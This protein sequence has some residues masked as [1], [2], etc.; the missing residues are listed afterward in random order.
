MDNILSLPPEIFRLQVVDVFYAL[1][2]AT[3]GGL[4]SWL[5]THKYD[6]ANRREREESDRRMKL[7]LYRSVMAQNLGKQTYGWTY[8]FHRNPSGL[9]LVLVNSTGE[10]V[11]GL[12][13]APASYDWMWNK[14]RPSDGSRP[15]EPRL[16]SASDWS[17]KV[18]ILEPDNWN[19]PTQEPRINS[20]G[21]P[22]F[23]LEEGGQ[24]F[25]RIGD[26]AVGVDCVLL[27]YN[28][29]EFLRRLK[30]PQGA[31]VEGC[32]KL[33]VEIPIPPHESM[34]DFRPEDYA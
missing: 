27:S 17:S 23:L 32:P 2:G 16:G 18:C 30:V 26:D 21:V 8:S 19:H 14:K 28:S 33:L 7:F 24:A 12:S 15:D 11:S 10:A 20:N 13:I 6:E 25:I 22:E 3:L 4:V 34:P 5:I 9:E 31:E 1:L 29:P